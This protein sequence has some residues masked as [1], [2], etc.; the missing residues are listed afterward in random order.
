M[1]QIGICSDHAGYE[2]KELVKAQLIARGLS[3]KDFG[4]HSS[5]RCDYPD[6]A[7]P[8]GRAIQQG[9]LSRGI[10]VCGSGN[11]ISMVLNKYPR[12]R[13]ALCWDVELAKL[14]RE[15]NDANVLSLPARFITE[16]QAEEIVSAF[17]DTAFEGGR[18]QPRVDKIPIH[19]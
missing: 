8:M 6:F 5:E 15:H 7:H 18:H 16:Q 12:V 9:E 3:V 4:C 1:N 11:G 19:E 10:S 2:V 13:A 17:L 14:A